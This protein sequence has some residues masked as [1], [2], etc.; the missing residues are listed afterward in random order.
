LIGSNKFLKLRFVLKIDKKLNFG[1]DK[2]Q[3]HPVI[4][5]DQSSS[6]T[7]APFEF[8]D[9]FLANHRIKKWL[10]VKRFDSAHY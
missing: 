6:K 5:R 4:G 7:V 9:Y 3:I 10:R 2:M 8:D 1:F